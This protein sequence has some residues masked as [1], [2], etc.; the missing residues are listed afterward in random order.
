MAQNPLRYPVF[1]D[2]PAFSRRRRLRRRRAQPRL[3]PAD[4][5]LLGLSRHLTA[6]PRVRRTPRDTYGAPVPA[7]AVGMAVSHPQS[8]LSPSDALEAPETCERTKPR[9]GQS[10]GSEGELPRESWPH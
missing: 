7:R 9:H 8:P 3:Q 2:L 6:V 1:G 5:G 4:G 10:R